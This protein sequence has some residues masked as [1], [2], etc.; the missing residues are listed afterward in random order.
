LAACE[1]WIKVWITYGRG[2][3]HDIIGSKSDGRILRTI[4]T[5]LW[6]K[7]FLVRDRTPGQMSKSCHRECSVA[8]NPNRMIRHPR[9]LQ[10]SIGLVKSSQ[11]AQEKWG[12]SADHQRKGGGRRLVGHIAILPK[13]ANSVGPENLKKLWFDLQFFVLN[14]TFLLI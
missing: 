5:I 2:I 4:R 11:E 6:R 1:R 8:E 10:C 3:F 7:V 12:G 9:S 13:N 14:T